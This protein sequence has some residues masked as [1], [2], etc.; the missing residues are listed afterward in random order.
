PRKRRRYRPRRAAR[1]PR[2]VTNQTR[3][4]GTAAHRAPRPTLRSLLHRPE[5]A[6]RH[7]DEREELAAVLLQRRDGGGILPLPRSCPEQ[8]I[9]PAVRLQPSGGHRH[10]LGGLPLEAQPFRR[11][12]GQCF[13]PDQLL[14]VRR[15]AA[16]IADF[17]GERPRRD[18]DLAAWLQ[19]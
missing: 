9:A 11:V 12:P 6:C 13:P 1:R 3:T 17:A 18:A 5:L 4:P 14:E 15:D 10:H 2:A 16:E 7:D 19:E 8:P